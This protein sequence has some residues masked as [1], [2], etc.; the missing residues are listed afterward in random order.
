MGFGLWALFFDFV[1]AAEAVR[2]AA[3]N[4]KDLSP[5]TKAQYKTT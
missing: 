1:F 2:C 5:K 4:C 3:L